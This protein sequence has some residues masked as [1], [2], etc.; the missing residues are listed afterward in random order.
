MFAKFRFRLGLSTSVASASNIDLLAI[1]TGGG[2]ELPGAGACAFKLED[3][4]APGTSFF[5]LYKNYKLAGVGVK[6]YPTNRSGLMGSTGGTTD[7]GT[8]PGLSI[9]MADNQDALVQNPDQLLARPQ[10]KVWYH[11]STKPNSIFIKPKLRSLLA[12]KFVTSSGTNA[13]QINFL[14]TPKSGWLNCG[15]AGD[16]SPAGAVLRTTAVTG[17]AHV[18]DMTTTE[19]L[20]C[21]HF[22]LKWAIDGGLTEVQD[23][24]IGHFI[25]TY[26]VGFKNIRTPGTV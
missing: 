25:F 15:N 22:G 20:Q 5:Q 2:A 14:S 4:S 3:V 8:G 6:F 7:G 26:Y 13:S 19:Y 18:D 1:K 10:A 16:P 12:S 11:G 24:N 23:A 21:E 9:W 17:A